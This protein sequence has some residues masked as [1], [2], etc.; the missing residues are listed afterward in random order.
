M[1]P[2]A[3]DL[4]AE[5]GVATSTEELDA[6]EAQAAGRVT[7]L[8]AVAQARTRLVGA[9][10]TP[11][12]PTPT[13]VQPAIANR[14]PGA[15]AAP[16]LLPEPEAYGDGPRSRLSI[17]S[18]VTLPDPEARGDGPGRVPGTLAEPTTLP[19]PHARA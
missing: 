14:S 17:A 2:T 19:E 5:A 12:A 3:Q 16:T 7:I 15:L 6:I 18:P 4:I 13:A 10:G 1:S 8:E 11:P 9:E